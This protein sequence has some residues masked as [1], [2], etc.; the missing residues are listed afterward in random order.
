MNRS[1]RSDL[2]TILG[3][4]LALFLLTAPYIIPIVLNAFWVNILTEILIWS[5]FAASVNLLFGYTGLLSFGQALFFGMGAY[6]VAFGL[7]TFGMSFWPAFLLGV[8]AATVTAAVTGIFAV[9]LTWSYFTIITVVF[10]LI[11]YL[12]AVGRKDITNG[13]DGMAFRIPPVVKLGGWEP[14]LLDLTFQYY[15]VLLV[16]AIF[17]LLLWMVLRSPLGYAFM[18]IRENDQRASLVGLNPYRIRYYSFVLAGLLAG[19][20]GVLFALFSRYTTAQYMFW[21]VSGEGVVWVVIGGAGTLLGPALGTALLIILREELSVYWE[22]FL[23][24]VGIIVIITVIFEPAGLMG[25]L[26]RWRDRSQ[27]PK[28]MKHLAE[29]SLRD[30]KSGATES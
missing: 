17:F 18:A 4:L 14:T 25:M 21:T 30:A 15:F 7:D 6:G 10:S 9:R 27:A 12:F 24:L 1:G 29:A 13:D 22:H 5:L 19:I 8:A 11:F 16:V 26:N 23:I 28:H 20:A 2:F 3:V